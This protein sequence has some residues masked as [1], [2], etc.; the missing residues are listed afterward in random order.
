MVGRSH[1]CV[2]QSQLYVG[3]GELCWHMCQLTYADENAEQILQDF[4]LFH[5][6]QGFKPFLSHL[7]LG[8]YFLIAYNYCV[9]M[10]TLW[11]S[12]AS[13]PGAQ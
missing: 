11:S 1:T 12:I 10:P 3:S 6:P 8:H 9:S 7:Q 13:F 2:G 4:W 5:G